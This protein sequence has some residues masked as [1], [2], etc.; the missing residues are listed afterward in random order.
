MEQEIECKYRIGKIVKPEKL[1]WLTEEKLNEYVNSSLL[2]R[3]TRDVIIEG[4]IFHVYLS[5]HDYRKVYL[6]DPVGSINAIIKQ[7]K[8]QLK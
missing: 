1:E 7:I 2:F 5:K 8:E 4:H 3:E 6:K